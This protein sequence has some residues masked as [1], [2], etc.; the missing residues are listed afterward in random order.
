MDLFSRKKQNTEDADEMEIREPELFIRPKREKHPARIF[1][2][3]FVLLFSA[4]VIALLL[5]DR[6]RAVETAEVP[7]E[8]AAPVETL[9]TPEVELVIPD[10]NQQPEQ[11]Q[12]DYPK[13]EKNSVVY[14]IR[15]NA[16][17]VV[18]SI[19]GAKN[20]KYLT[21]EKSVRKQ[22]PVV[23]ICEGAFKDCVKLQKVH[24]PDSVIIIR[25]SAFENCEKLEQVRMSEGLVTIGKRVFAGCASLKSLKFP[26]SV[27]ELSADVFEGALS[28]TD[29][30]IPENCAIPAGEDPFG[31]GDSLMI[32]IYR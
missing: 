7:V 13:V 29:L 28:L 11:A 10:Y 14:E 15:N 25:D 9:A 22:Y 1:S 27:K 24:I 4:A 16:A 8:T 31:L 21:I 5:S 20:M 23:E 30:R 32:E 19:G 18:G 26:A 12:I 2:L 3:L 6:E 17:Y